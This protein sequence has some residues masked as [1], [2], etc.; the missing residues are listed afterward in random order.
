MSD[1]NEDVIKLIIEG[2]DEYSDVSEEV[3][4]ELDKLAGEA[5]DTRKAFNELEGALALAEVYREQE[6]EVQ[7]LAKA[8]AEAKQ[9]VDQL[10]VANKQA[11]GENL[12]LVA[13]LAK[14]KA[15]FT[16]LRTSTN[17]AQKTLDKTS[18]TMR[19]QGVALDEVE[20]NQKHYREGVAK[21]SRKLTELSQAQT[22]LIKQGRQEAAV[23]LQQAKAKEQQAFSTS[24]LNQAI[25]N[26][27][28][29][30][31]GAVRGI[32][33][34][35]GQ[36]AALGGT[37]LGIH[38]VK[39]AISGIL[40]TGAKFEQLDTQ[41]NTLMGSIEE[42]EKATAWIK[43]FATKT[44]TD[45]EG[46]T[47]GFVKLKAFGIDPMNGS[48]QAIID[49]TSKLGFSQ[50]KM[51]GVI[52]AVGQAWTK[53]K[54]QGEEAL[55]LIERGVPVWDLLS[56]ATGKTAVEL[57]KLAT[58]GELGR[59]EIALLIEE[60]GK[61]AKGA[62]AAQ[63]DTWDGMISNLSDSWTGF[64]NLIAEA[65]VFDYAKEQ[66][67]ALLDLS[68]EMAE[69]G[70]LMAY[71][72]QISDTLV[73]AAD[74]VKSYLTTVTE[75]F[76]S[77]VSGSEKVMA[78]FS[79][80]FNSFTAGVKAIAQDVTQSISEILDGLASGLESIKL[81]DTANALKDKANAMRAVSH[82]FK[83]ELEQDAKDIKAAW[84]T[85][86]GHDFKPAE[87]GLKSLSDESAKAAN[88]ITSEFQK[89]AT[90][91][92]S[93]SEQIRN[94]F[95]S[96]INT[97]KTAEEVQQLKEAFMRL[98]WQGKVTSDDLATGLQRV[99]GALEQIA[100]Q[101]QN[102]EKAMNGLS[103]S[104]QGIKNYL[105]ELDK[106]AEAQRKKTT[107]TEADTKKTEENTQATDKNTESV[108]LNRGA[109]LT[110]A[111][112]TAS[113]W[114]NASEEMGAAYDRLT[115]GMA[116]AVNKFGNLP[117]AAFSYVKDF[118]SAYWDAEA[119]AKRLQG[120]FEMQ[121][122]ALNSHLK[123]LTQSK[124]VTE[125]MV[126]RAEGALGA[127]TLLGDQQLAPLRNAIAAIRADMDQ[128]TDSLENTVDRL[129]DELDQL[130]GDSEAIQER[131][132]QK[133][134]SEL[135]DLLD[136][137]RQQRNDEALK[138]AQEALRLLE[139]TNRIKRENARA[140]KQQAQN[141]TTTKER[142]PT[143]EVKRTIAIQ[144]G[145]ESRM[146]SLADETSEQNLIDTL[147]K[148]GR[149]QK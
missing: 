57:Q 14:A 67:Q 90:S 37:Y 132:Y 76:D 104:S 137:A 53:Q 45:L 88:A 79:L 99:D 122:V 145:N 98:Q 3:R 7:R 63:M 27:A 120:H 149:V 65:G 126:N 20:R 94:A 32:G 60:M 123:T 34:L 59:K 4:Q 87:D 38:T 51:E 72:K 143:S 77:L 50:D 80:V 39:D 58:K 66:L 100:I 83:E 139:Q 81:D 135:N 107:A 23:A 75:N 113:A 5:N 141:S 52:L 18:A 117:R 85:L 97:A 24:K 78:G 86:T 41:I 108:R 28:P 105:A 46:V 61:A 69:D 91:A 131:A 92:D 130:N 118:A 19:K 25:K 48:Y 144:M 133:E 112:Q 40:E 101:A 93:T 106:A 96:G 142:P 84:D 129:R 148:L 140:E 70:R 8:Q 62:A 6:A 2:K 73:N 33:G 82:A 21:L 11:K 116:N 12:E 74:N 9:R 55:Q 125:E 30:S 13:S 147:T 128:L 15:E 10:T 89:I 71:A 111:N 103:L 146:V 31:T 36:L 26:M 114:H 1:K 109:A 121:Q 49:Q 16:S 44:P 22:K 115:Q 102:A 29:T 95:V 134:K 68:K 64:V 42:G 17:Q 119:S 124:H 43:D 127:Y 110:L 56:K 35:T 54:L 136:L 47:S 138:E